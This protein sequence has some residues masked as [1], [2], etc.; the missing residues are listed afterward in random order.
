MNNA[1]FH[2]EGKVVDLINVCNFIIYGGV[3][4]DHQKTNL[5]HIRRAVSSHD[6]TSQFSIM[7]FF[8]CANNLFRNV[9]SCTLLL[10]KLGAFLNVSVT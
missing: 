10:E 2:A 1:K 6:L 8:E 9:A 5:L 3:I 4:K 7:Y